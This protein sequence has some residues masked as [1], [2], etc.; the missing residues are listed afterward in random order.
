MVNIFKVAERLIIT[1]IRT[2]E[3]LARP[4]DIRE[5]DVETGQDIRKLAKKRAR[6]EGV[7]LSAA[8]YPRPTHLVTVPR[9]SIK[10]HSGYLTFARK[11][12]PQ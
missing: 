12:L 6:Q 4:Y 3:C 10:G 11:M 7:V 8:E 5:I 2:I 9:A 1:E